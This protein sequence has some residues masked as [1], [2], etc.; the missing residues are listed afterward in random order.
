MLMLMPMVEIMMDAHGGDKDDG[1]MRLVLMVV[2][3]G[4]RMRC[5][6]GDAAPGPH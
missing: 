3:K 5:R 1:V 2:E 4:M 6:W